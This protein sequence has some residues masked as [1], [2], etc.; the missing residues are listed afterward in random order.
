MVTKT[1]AEELR[2]HCSSPSGDRQAPQLWDPLS[3][4][5]GGLG[6]SPLSALC[7]IPHALAISSGWCRRKDGYREILSYNSIS[8][9][10]CLL[11]FFLFSIHRILKCMLKMQTILFAAS[12]VSAGPFCSFFRSVG[13]ENRCCIR[14][15]VL[16]TVR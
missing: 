7:T 2:S 16:I 11:G 15:L 3:A 13:Y 10:G 4:L 5:L 6:L 14:S 1:P 9:E 8:Y 12:L